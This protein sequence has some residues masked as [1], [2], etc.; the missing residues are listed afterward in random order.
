MATK[1]QLVVTI[2]ELAARL[3]IDCP[4]AWCYRQRFE[5]EDP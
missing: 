5:S 4:G 1:P 3:G 2:E